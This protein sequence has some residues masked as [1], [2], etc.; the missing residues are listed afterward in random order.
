MT[1]S[2]RDRSQPLAGSLD[3]FS[4]PT[5]L[6][7]KMKLGGRNQAFNTAPSR[8]EAPGWAMIS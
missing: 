1:C 2:R 5:V 4:L 8:A 7:H 6:P 3:V